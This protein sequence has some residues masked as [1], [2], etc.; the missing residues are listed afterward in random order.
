MIV[1]AIKYSNYDPPEIDSLWLHRKAAERACEELNEEALK[2][3]VS[4]ADNWEVT[5]M[6]VH[7]DEV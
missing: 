6:T 3:P 2:G 4:G 7:E 1:Y 5:P